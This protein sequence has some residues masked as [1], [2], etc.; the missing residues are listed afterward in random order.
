MKTASLFPLALFL[1]VLIGCG[2]AERERREAA[3]KNLEEEKKALEQ[4]NAKEQ[5]AA[6]SLAVFEKRILPI[7][8]S[9]KPSSCSECHLSGVNLKEYIRPIRLVLRKRV[10]D[11]QKIEGIM[12][13]AG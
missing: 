10:D 3:K 1:I 12:L 13:V 7:F 8:R 2:Q 5:E 6:A 11:D 4:L 9:A